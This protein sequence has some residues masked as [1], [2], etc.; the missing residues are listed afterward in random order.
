MAIITKQGNT[1][2]MYKGRCQYC[3]C[4]FLWGVYEYYNGGVKCPQCGALIPY[5]NPA[6]FNMPYYQQQPYGSGQP[7]TVS[8]NK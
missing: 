4:E 1:V 5:V 2:G 6:Y 3:G 7:N 8:G